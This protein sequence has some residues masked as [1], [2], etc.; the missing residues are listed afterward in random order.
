MS[1]S[2]SRMRPDAFSR[3]WLCIWHYTLAAMD[4]R[5][6]DNFWLFFFSAVI[7]QPSHV[8]P[9]ASRRH[10]LSSPSSSLHIYGSFCC[11]WEKKVSSQSSKMRVNHLFCCAWTLIPPS[12]FCA[13]R[14]NHLFRHFTFILLFFHTGVVTSN[15]IFF[16]GGKV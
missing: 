5:T 4:G 15:H 10:W 14:N 6:D 9:P 11:C 12:D 1:L 16:L 13:A 8:Y 3:V 7:R 2:N